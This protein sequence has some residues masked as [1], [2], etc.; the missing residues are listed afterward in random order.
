MTWSIG[1]D[2]EARDNLIHYLGLEEKEIR[3]QEANVGEEI[4]EYLL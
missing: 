3:K 1:R 2:G 4:E